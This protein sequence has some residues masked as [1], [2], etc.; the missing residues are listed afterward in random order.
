MNPFVGLL[1]VPLVAAFGIQAPSSG[2]P[3]S[4]AAALEQARRSRSVGDNQQAEHLF[5]LAADLWGKEKGPESE[6]LDFASRNW[7]SSVTPPADMRGRVDLSP[8]A[9]HPREDG[10]IGTPGLCQIS[11]Q[12]GYAQ[13][14]SGAAA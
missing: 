2:P 9:Q 4:A 11:E 10:R 5:L 13:K 1:A 12:S 3:A 7:A 14:G 6:E 8:G